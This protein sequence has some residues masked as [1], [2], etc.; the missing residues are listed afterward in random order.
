MPRSPLTDLIR[1]IDAVLPQTQCEQCGYRGCEAYARAIAEGEAAINR[2]PPGGREGIAA[3]AKLL[4]V[5]EIE[6]DTARG[7]QVPFEVAKITEAQ[8]IGCRH[9]VTACPTD[10]IIGNKKHL[11]RVD[12]EYCTGCALCTIKCPVDCIE[13]IRVDAVWDKEK[14][15]VARS[16][17]RAKQKRQ[18]EWQMKIDE[19]LASHSNADLKKNF[20]AFLR[21]RKMAG[22]S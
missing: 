12:I 16:R 4:G 6:P 21:Q 2:C 19:K 7:V 13:M 18:E 1:G 11:H 5:E 14:A 15:D 9:C 20:L 8:C 3:L 10:A 22:K 17:F